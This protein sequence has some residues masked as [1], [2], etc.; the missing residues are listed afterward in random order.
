MAKAKS[1]T[2]KTKKIRKSATTPAGYDALPLEQ[3][4]FLVNFNSTRFGGASNLVVYVDPSSENA[5]KTTKV[6]V[7]PIDILNELEK[8]PTNFSLGGI[9]DKIAILRLKE[10]LITQHY[11]KQDIQALIACLEARKKYDTPA[12]DKKSFREYFSQFDATNDAKITA[13]TSKYQLEFGDADLF[14][15]EFPDIAVKTMKEYSSK[16][17][18]LTGKKPHFFVI[19]TSSAFTQNRER[20]DPILL[21]QSPFGFYYYILGAWDKEMLYLPE[22]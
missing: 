20:R 10:E 17:V 18:E 2:K 8:V 9:D 3:D 19:A 16:V 4:T 12:K 6:A 22:L 14:V 1:K 5:P 15:P 13:L 11:A 21:A 7:K